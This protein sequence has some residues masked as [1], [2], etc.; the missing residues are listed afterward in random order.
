MIVVA[1]TSVL[2]GALDRRDHRHPECAAV[3]RKRLDSGLVV[4][5]A[6]A[7]EVDYLV[8]TRVGRD[9]ARTFLRNL[10]TG[11]LVLEPVDSEILRRAVELDDHYADLGLGLADGTVVATAEKHRAEAILSLD[12]HYRLVAPDFPVEPG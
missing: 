8:S 6:V 9:A 7:V 2:V 5:A 4:T 3:V 11:V 12:H 1:D 10:D